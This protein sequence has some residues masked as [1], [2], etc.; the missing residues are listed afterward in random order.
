MDSASRA[1][2]AEAIG[3]RIA[4]TDEQLAIMRASPDALDAILCCFAGMAVRGGRLAVARGD[5]GNGEGWIA[6]HA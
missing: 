5:G 6:V 2:I 3:R 1:R 4:C